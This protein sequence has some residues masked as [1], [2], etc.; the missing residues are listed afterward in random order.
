MTKL[1][2]CK[3]AHKVRFG[4]E[5]IDIPKGTMVELDTEYADVGDVLLGYHLADNHVAWKRTHASVLNKFD[6]T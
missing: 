2:K 3:E 5:T 1:Y 6:I 4:G